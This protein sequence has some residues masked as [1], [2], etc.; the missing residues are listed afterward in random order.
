MSKGDNTMDEQDELPT[1]LKTIYALLDK[2]VDE[3]ELDLSDVQV[4][5]VIDAMYGV[6]KWRT[7]TIKRVLD[8]LCS[9]V[10]R[11]A[12]QTQTHAMIK[13][14]DTLTENINGDFEKQLWDMGLDFEDE[15]V[16]AAIKVAKE[17]LAYGQ[18]K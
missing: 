12:P 3:A 14:L 9:A 7:G 16:I 11:R 6:L 18:K 17:I 13:Q 8:Q 10:R 4:S 1:Y 5:S 2:R 15:A